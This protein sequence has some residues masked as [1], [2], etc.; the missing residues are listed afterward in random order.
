MFERRTTTRTLFAMAFALAALALTACADSARPPD[1][2][3]IDP[4]DAAS[5]DSGSTDSGSTDASDASTPDSG[6]ACP[7]VG[8]PIVDPNVFAPCTP[9]CGGAHCLPESLVP[10]AGRSVLSA[11]TAPYGAGYCVPD[12]VIAS[13]GN[14]VPATCNAVPG[15]SVE[16]RCLSDCLPGVA[17]IASSLSVDVCATGEHCVPCFDPFTGASTGACASVSCDMPAQPAYTFPTCCPSGGT[18]QATCLPS[19]TIPS[20]AQPALQQLTCPT[21][22]LCVPDELVPERGVTAQT[23]GIPAQPSTCVSRCFAGV[24]ANAPQGSCPANH[25]CLRCSL[26]PAGTPGCP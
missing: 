12:Q 24:P 19:A 18:D 26:L 11:C 9:S 3:M 4:M 1:G 10:V 20:A 14:G 25:A 8:P 7:Y 16:G 23:C 5:T 2:S 17:A 15:A 6:L 22:F 13:G 21:D